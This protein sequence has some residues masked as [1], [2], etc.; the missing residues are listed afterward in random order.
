MKTVSELFMELKSEKSIIKYLKTLPDDT[1]IKYN[2]DVEYSPFPI[3]VM[4]EYQRRFHHKTKDE[5]LKK[6]QVQARLAKRKTNEL[7][8]MAK[9][10][11]LVSDVT[12]QKSEEVLAQAKK[13]GYE[14]GGNLAKKSSSIAARI[15]KGAQKGVKRGVKAG[16][17]LKPPVGKK[18]ELLEK[19]AELKKAGILTNKE[20]QEKK[21][22]ILSKI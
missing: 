7:K 6:L 1:I 19:L 22:K 13:K 9:R 12:Q 20:F 2:L 4:Q 16:K 10:E 15:K 14:I 21:E 11:K 17:S 5:I 18:I 3:L 8:Q